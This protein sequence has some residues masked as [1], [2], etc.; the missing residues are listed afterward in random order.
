WNAS[1]HTIHFNSRFKNLYIIHLPAY[2][3]ELD[4]IEQVW[5]SLRANDLANFV[6]YKNYEHIVDQVT[7]NGITSG[8][9][10]NM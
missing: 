8:I 4:P 2:S 5:A 1:W 6:A 9:K 7:N 10:S 3:P